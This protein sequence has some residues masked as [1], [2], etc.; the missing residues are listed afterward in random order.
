M[1]R[2]YFTTH[3]LALKTQ[4]P[5]KLLIFLFI[6]NIV[7]HSFIL[8]FTSTIQ[9]TPTN[10]ENYLPFDDPNIT[11]LMVSHYGCEKQHNLRHFNLIKVKQCTE[12]PSNIQHASGPSLC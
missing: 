1:A 7:L 3:T 8:T 2:L 12:V 5:F 11:N 6:T 4:L 9:N 10:T